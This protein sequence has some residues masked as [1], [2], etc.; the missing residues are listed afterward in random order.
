MLNALQNMEKR[1]TACES[2]IHSNTEE[3]RRRLQDMEDRL[4][5]ILQEKDAKYNRLESI[6]DGVR[7]VVYDLVEGVYDQ[8]T[9][10]SIIRD[11]ERHLYP[12]PDD[13]RKYEEVW[14]WEVCPTTRWPTTRQGDKCVSRITELEVKL[15][16]M[17][18]H[19]EEWRRRFKENNELAWRR[20]LE[21]ILQMLK[22]EQDD[23]DIAHNN[24]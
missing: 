17:Q 10:R 22:R 15:I 7:N 1:Q 21:R 2:D 13:I 5:K 23:I 12:H 8:V 18:E 9:Q 14:D 16:E 11:H 6:L 19:M 4:E 3:M 24:R 20:N